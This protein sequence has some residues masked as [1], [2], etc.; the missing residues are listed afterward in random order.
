NGIDGGDPRVEH[1]LDPAHRA[2]EESQHDAG[3]RAI[4]ETLHHAVQAHE[5]GPRELAGA[6]HLPH[7]GED[8]ER[9]GE[10]ELG[11]LA[12]LDEELPKDEE[13]DD[14]GEL[15]E[16]RSRHRAMAWVTSSP[17]KASS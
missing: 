8:G 6:C 12:R 3:G 14:R 7:R 13:A 9:R 16:M 5:H 2:C 1:V 17:R 11:E 4:D 10:E 15:T